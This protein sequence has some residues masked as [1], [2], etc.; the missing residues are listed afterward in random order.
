MLAGAAISWSSKKLQTTALSSTEAEYMSVSNASSETVYIRQILEDMGLP[1]STATKV[2]CDN[3]GAVHI[4]ND[5]RS[6]HHAKHIRRRYHFIREL[7]EEGLVEIKAIA[8][9]INWADA[10]TKPL[11][12]FKFARFRN[13]YMGESFQKAG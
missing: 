10:M 9:D 7:V 3:K 1:P 12:Q 11:E 2:F 8:T 6:L 13:F 4:A 5:R